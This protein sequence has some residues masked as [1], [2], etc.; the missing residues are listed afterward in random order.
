[1]L[2]HIFQVLGAFALIDDGE[3][4]WKVLVVDVTPVLAALADFINSFNSFTRRLQL[5][6]TIEG[7]Q[8]FTDGVCLSFFSEAIAVRRFETKQE[9]HTPLKLPHLFQQKHQSS[10]RA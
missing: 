9:G 8:D 2:Q 6:I 4:D 3:T 10:S 1:M 7:M 5:F